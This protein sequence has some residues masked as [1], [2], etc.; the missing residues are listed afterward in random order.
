[1]PAAEDFAIFSFSTAYNWDVSLDTDGD[2]AKI[3][4]VF[5]YLPD[6]SGTAGPDTLLGPP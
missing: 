6:A 3:C 2:T 4:V 1:M 5:E